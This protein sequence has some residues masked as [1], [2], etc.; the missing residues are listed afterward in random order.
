MVTCALGIYSSAEFHRDRSIP[1][2]RAR[3]SEESGTSPCATC[4]GQEGSHQPQKGKT[5]DW[6]RRLW[7]IRKPFQAVLRKVSISLCNTGSHQKCKQKWKQL[8]LGNTERKEDRKSERP[9]K[10]PLQWPENKMVGHLK[11]G[12]K[13]EGKKFW[14]SNQTDRRHG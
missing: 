11:T 9:G 7:Q 2:Y 1:K 12:M 4:L 10:W 6:R 8:S 13:T 5:Q 14:S 3:H